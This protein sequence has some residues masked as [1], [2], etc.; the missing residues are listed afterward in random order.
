MALMQIILK[1]NPATGKQN[2]WVKLDSDPDALPIEHEQ[3][4]RKLVEKLVGA[5]LDPDDLGEMI[6]EREATPNPPEAETTTE[7][8]RQK[9][10]Q[11]R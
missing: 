3:L 2:I 7:P 6:V 1:R 10:A 5:G 11:G 8:E 4:H 9:T